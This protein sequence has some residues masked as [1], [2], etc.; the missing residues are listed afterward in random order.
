M[1]RLIYIGVIVALAAVLTGCFKDEKQGTCMHIA[2][3]SQNVADDPIMKCTS[4]IE[5]YAFKVNKGSKWEVSTWE[6]A[7]AHCITNKDNKSEQLTEPDIYGTYDPEAEFQVTFELWAHFTF[8]VIVDKTNKI[9]ATRLY[10]TPMNLPAM[11]TY[12]HL[13]AWRK[14]GAANGWDVTNPFP[15][16]AREPLVPVEPEPTPDGGTEEPTPEE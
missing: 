3:Y 12:L 10:E 1:K 14:S 15:D 2:L 4:D 16:E 9:Y 13:Y 6:D 7:L 8:L 11:E 5:A